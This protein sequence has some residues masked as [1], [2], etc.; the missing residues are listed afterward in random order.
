MFKVHSYSYI[1]IGIV[2][3]VW[4]LIDCFKKGQEQEAEEALIDVIESS[5]SGDHYL[6]DLKEAE[7]VIGD[8]L[9]EAGDIKHFSRGELTCV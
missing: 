4:D 2:N 3:D 1:I 6:V 5:Y 9:E 8:T 7:R